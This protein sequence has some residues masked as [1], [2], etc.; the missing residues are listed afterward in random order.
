MVFH[1][2]SAGG[3]G[4]KSQGLAPNIPPST[5]GAVGVCTIP[6]LRRWATSVYELHVVAKFRV[7]GVERYSWNHVATINARRLRV[8]RIR[9][10][11]NCFEDGSNDGFH[12]IVFLRNF[13]VI[14]RTYIFAA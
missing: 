9:K 1:S 5:R 14:Y 8:R 12:M 10:C 7:L 11:F 3:R 6:L 13:W 2:G 4:Q